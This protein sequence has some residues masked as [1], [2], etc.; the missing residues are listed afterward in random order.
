MRRP[1]QTVTKKKLLER[2]RKNSLAL[3]S[4]SDVHKVALKYVNKLFGNCGMVPPPY[5]Y[6]GPGIPY[7]P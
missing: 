6:L 2:L 1:L 5:N 4:K 7:I 3:K